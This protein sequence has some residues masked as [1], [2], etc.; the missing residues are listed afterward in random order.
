MAHRLPL[1]LRALGSV[2]AAGSAVAL[3]RPAF[4]SDSNDRR[5]SPTPLGQVFRSYLVYSLCSIPP[6]VDKSPKILE[7]LSAIPGVASLTEAFVR[8]TF[9]AQFVGGDT[10]LDTLPLLRQLRKDNKGILFAYSVED[11]EESTGAEGSSAYKERVE[12][13]IRCI[14]VAADFE[15]SSSS[16]TALGRRTWVAV[17]L[18]AL[19]PSAEPLRTLS[20]H[21][22]ATRPPLAVPFP[23]HA[24]PSDLAVL[25]TRN[26][27]VHSGLSAGDVK[28]LRELRDDLRR[29]VRIIV[30]A[31][32]TW[33]QPA[34]D[35]YTHSL[36]RTFNR[37]TGV[38]PLVYGTFQAYLRRTHAQ[39]TH[40]I[41]D[42]RKEGY[43]LGVKLVRGAYHPHECARHARLPSI[44]S[45]PPVWERIE[46]TDAQYLA[47]TQLLLNAVA[48]DVNRP[49]SGWFSS[50]G[51]N[52][53]PR[54]GVL[55]G[56]HNPSSCEAIVRGMLAKG[57]ASPVASPVD[58][59]DS[60]FN[61]PSVRIDARV[62]ER[63]AI[64][65]L[66]GMC[67]WLTNT[68]VDRVSA[69]FPFVIKYVPYGAL[70]EVMP[71][72]S[73]RAIE[74]KSVLGGR[75][76]ARE[77][78]KRAGEELRIVGAGQAAAVIEEVVPPLFGMARGIAEAAEVRTVQT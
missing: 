12:E 71:Y 35:A 9:Y 61:I 64:G 4:F 55:F 2:L 74:N 5:R 66:Y 38:Q 44:Q 57:L 65:Q 52:D 27:N 13:T 63:L 70:V 76:G 16:P 62:A 41:A 78:R 26:V 46:D 11:D 51:K 68:L 56:T 37:D 25:D 24:R 3:S 30:D 8:R 45:P 73:R 53:T 31:E 18:S 23:G 15:D 40:A 29:G 7:T 39:L 69:P 14:D 49:S 59:D 10:A 75:G 60:E 6:L 33:W 50:S 47:C 34:I 54:I 20:T 28:I 1:R 22:E 36:M 67:D 42:A 21:L 19:V 17:K 43:A 48:A 72:L 77:E 58:G 32:Y